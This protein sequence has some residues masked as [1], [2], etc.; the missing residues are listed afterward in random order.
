MR[1]TGSKGRTFVSRKLSIPKS[2]YKW[3]FRKRETLNEKKNCKF[4]V[5]FVV[6]DKHAYLLLFIFI[7]KIIKHSKYPFACVEKSTDSFDYF[8]FQANIVH[9]LKCIRMTL[10]LLLLAPSIRKSCWK[11]WARNAM[12]LV[13][14]NSVTLFYACCLLLLLL[15]WVLKNFRRRVYTGKRGQSSFYTAPTSF[16]YHHVFINADSSFWF[17]IKIKM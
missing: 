2:E 15:L 11:G 9:R 7:R 10:L 16:T 13:A 8:N 12:L 1:N 3:K 14:P 6:F 4:N 17:K 5:T